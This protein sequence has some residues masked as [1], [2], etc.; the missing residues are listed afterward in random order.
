MTFKG[1]MEYGLRGGQL[2]WDEA[3]RL[4]LPNSRFQILQ[5]TKVDLEAFQLQKAFKLKLLTIYSLQTSLNYL[6]TKAVLPIFKAI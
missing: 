6:P 4:K 3:L 5:S 2:L 1:K